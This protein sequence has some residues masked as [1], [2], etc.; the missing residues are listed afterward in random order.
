MADVTDESPP[1][2]AQG[3]QTPWRSLLARIGL[4]GKLII[5]FGL[6]LMAALTCTSALY[7]H[8][9]HHA[10]PD[11]LGEQARQISQTLAMAA[12]PAYQDG[13]T[14]ELTR[15]GKDLLKSRNIVL[16]I[17]Y[18]ASGKPIATASRDPNFSPGNPA[19]AGHFQPHTQS[20]MK[21]QTSYLPTLGNFLQ[22]T[23]P[24]VSNNK[25]GF[26]RPDSQLQ[27]Y[28]TVG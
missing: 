21:V 15:L 22:V 6:L 12:E 25:R 27:G 23:A 10:L 14:Q 8:K 1:P 26:F 2:P 3:R 7:V 20:L 19:M 24:V 16:V 17:F 28:L 4:Q 11:I 13:D 5:A 9:C 18:D